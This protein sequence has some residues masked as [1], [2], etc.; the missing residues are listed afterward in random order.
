[1]KNMHAVAALTFVNLGILIFV[2]FH[3]TAP[4]QASSTEASN[5]RTRA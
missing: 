1:M 2:L 5:S 3:Q 4:V